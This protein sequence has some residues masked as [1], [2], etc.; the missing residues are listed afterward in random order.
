M[1]IE[2]RPTTPLRMF[3]KISVMC[4][5]SALTYDRME[6]QRVVKCIGT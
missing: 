1:E 6:T 4:A 3:G 2:A 5:W